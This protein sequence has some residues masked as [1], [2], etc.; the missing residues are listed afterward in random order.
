M[1]TVGQSWTL[2]VT[3]AGLLVGAVTLGGFIQ[4]AQ[5]DAQAAVLERAISDVNTKNNSLSTEIGDLKRGLDTLGKMLRN[6][7]SNE[8]SLKGEV[9]FLNRYLSYQIRPNDAS[10]AL[11]V[12]MVCA[13]WRESAR[14]RVRIDHVPLRITSDQLQR[15]LSAEI[16]GLLVQHGVSSTTIQK[17]A[18]P[19]V[20]E[21]QV[22]VAPF[23]VRRD[24]P[25]PDVQRAISEVQKQA[26]AIGLTKTVT[27]PDGLSF[28]IPP[29]IAFVVHTR[30]DCAP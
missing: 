10:K 15:G 3:A 6:S 11:F 2:A 21:R 9:E 14:R 19:P 20:I 16:R 12:N 30:T 18:G 17:A 22:G 27:F 1:L 8:Q 24:E 7:E 28:D 4:K 5:G 26:G 13:M 29:E 23:V 25:N